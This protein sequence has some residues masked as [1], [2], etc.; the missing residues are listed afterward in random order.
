MVPSAQPVS[1]GAQC[2]MR[3][4]D[5]TTYA[6]APKLPQTPH[7]CMPSPRTCMPSAPRGPGTHPPLRHLAAW[8]RLSPALRTFKLA[9]LP[10]PAHS[11]PPGLAAL[12]RAATRFARLVLNGA[13]RVPTPDPPDLPPRRARPGLHHVRRRARRTA[14]CG[15]SAL[16]LTEATDPA[17]F[18]DAAPLLP[19]VFASLRP[20]LHLVSHAPEVDEENIVTTRC[21]RVRHTR[22][23]DNQISEVSRAKKPCSS[24]GAKWLDS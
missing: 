22:S 24:R 8:A 15:C 16:A 7:T 17:V 9:F 10:A 2:R 3:N 11:Q 19:F 5:H 1:G 21:N 14:P 13:G 6:D 23:F 20:H 4:A 18:V 12:L